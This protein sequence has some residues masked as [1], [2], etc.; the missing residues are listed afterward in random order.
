[1]PGNETVAAIG[2]WSV[3]ATIAS[4]TRP[5]VITVFRVLADGFLIVQ[6]AL[7]TR[8][9]RRREMRRW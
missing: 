8:E 7:S 6:L 9:A 4:V 5:V 2:T 1:V 3:A